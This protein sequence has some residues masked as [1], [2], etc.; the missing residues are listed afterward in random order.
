MKRLKRLEILEGRREE[1]REM[2]RGREGGNEETGGT[3]GTER[4][5]QRRGDVANVGA[6]YVF[7]RR[8]I[9]QGLER[10]A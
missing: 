3:G 10:R 6:A 8:P 4:E 5:T 9:V 1:E 2:E 7:A